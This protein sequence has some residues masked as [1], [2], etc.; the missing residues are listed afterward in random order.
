MGRSTPFS[1]FFSTISL[2]LILAAPSAP[3]EECGPGFD[4]DT[5]ML[6]EPRMV[7][8]VFEHRNKY[9]GLDH[10]TSRRTGALQAQSLA[11]LPEPL[12]F[13]SRENPIVE[14]MLKSDID[15][16]KE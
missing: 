16:G 15:K 12:S 13:T 4:V 6:S 2:E 14:D 11:M 8:I 5:P 10:L 7:Y 1:F 3:F 9:I